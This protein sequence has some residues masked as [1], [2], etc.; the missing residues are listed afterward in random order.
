LFCFVNKRKGFFRFRRRNF[1][2][3]CCR[4]PGPAI[5]HATRPRRSGRLRLTGVFATR[6]LRINFDLTFQSV[7]RV[8]AVA[9]N[10]RC[11]TQKRQL[12]SPNLMLRLL[13]NPESRFMGS[14]Y[15]Q[16]P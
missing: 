14:G 15:W 3:Y 12:C 16:A 11:D 10:F 7:G 4:A 13:K 5:Q 8:V 6:P 1:D 2:L 9:R